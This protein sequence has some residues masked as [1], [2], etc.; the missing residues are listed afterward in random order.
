LIKA[1]LFD[2]DG[3]L[4]QVDMDEFLRHYFKKL[5]AHF[6]GLLDPMQFTA[7]LLAATKAMVCDTDAAKTNHEV[8]YQHFHKKLPGPRETVLQMV[9][10]FYETI[11][12]K[13]QH[14]VKPFPQT[15]QIINTAKA[16]GVPLVLATNPVFPRQAI[17]H[18]MNWAGI[19][20]EDFAL[21]TSCENM[22][23]CKPNP[24]YYL[25]IAD[26]LAV[27]PA[28]CL[29]IGNDADDD[30]AAAAK[31]GMKTYLAVDFL[32]NKSGRTPAP[33]YSGTV[34]DIPVFLKTL[35]IG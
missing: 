23:F 33:D 11:F 13:L 35:N 18:R 5:S 22:H 24:C 7:N 14:L 26:F 8:F 4:L 32:V 17:R 29:M 28:S 25:E 30:I 21:I 3:T 31:A 1:I 15:T 34:A 2:L 6:A 27:P 12:P 10:E 19:P 9:N 20:A 16:L